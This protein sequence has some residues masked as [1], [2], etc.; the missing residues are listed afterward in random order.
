MEY[1]HDYYMKGIREAPGGF[2]PV[3]FAQK[4]IEGKH[5]TEDDC[6]KA[7]KRRQEEIALIESVLA[8][9]KKQKKEAQ[10]TTTS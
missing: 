3:F 10:S 2:D 9:V 8:E 6:R 1:G 5:F 7:I 4:A